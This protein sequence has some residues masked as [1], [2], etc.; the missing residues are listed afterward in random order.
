M[1]FACSLDVERKTTIER[2]MNHA[3]S[4]RSHH[5]RRPFLTRK[6]DISLTNCNQA[7]PAT[8][9]DRGYYKTTTKNN[10][11]ILHDQ[12]P[13]PSWHLYSSSNECKPSSV[14]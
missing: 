13:F 7:L 10:E 12:R 4:C 1:L 2:Y 5:P 9:I 3:K 14:L 11:I 6:M 8:I